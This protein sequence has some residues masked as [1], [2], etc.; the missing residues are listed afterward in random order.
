MLNF[1]SI[2]NAYKFKQKQK[3][4][5]KLIKIFKFIYPGTKWVTVQKRL[6]S[7]VSNQTFCM[8]TFNSLLQDSHSNKTIY[9]KIIQNSDYF[10]YLIIIFF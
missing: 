3:Y 2:M 5:M 1:I 10:C 6:F 4:K 9:V 7:V 8:S